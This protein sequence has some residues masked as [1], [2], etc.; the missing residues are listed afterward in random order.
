MLNSVHIYCGIFNVTH[1][2]LLSLILQ[3]EIGTLKNFNNSIKELQYSHFSDCSTIQKLLSISSGNVFK[4][5]LLK[6]AL[7]E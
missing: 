7:N 2:V 4:D 5:Y 6:L 1:E 3:K